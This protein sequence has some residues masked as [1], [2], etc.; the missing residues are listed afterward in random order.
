[1]S[2]YLAVFENEDAART[3]QNKNSVL[4]Q[5]VLEPHYVHKVGESQAPLI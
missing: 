4:L 2:I 1:M 5:E 3:I